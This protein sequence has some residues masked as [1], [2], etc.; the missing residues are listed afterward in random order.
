MT[1]LAW[2]QHRVTFAAVLGLFVAVATLLFVSGQSMHRTYDELG[3]SNCLPPAH[4][5]CPTLALGLP[6]SF[7]NVSTWL[8]PFLL[9]PGL[10]G[11]FW[12]GPLVAREL[13]HGTHRLVWTQSISRHRWLLVKVAVMALATIAGL[14]ALTVLLAWWSAPAASAYGNSR[15]DPL[16]FDLLGIAPVAYG[17]AALALG[18]SAGT[19]S[20]KVVPAIALT[21]LALAVV[22]VGVEVGLRP[23]FMAPE[24]T[25]TSPFIGQPDDVGGWVL[26]QRIVAADGRTLDATFRPTEAGCGGTTAMRF[27]ARMAEACAPGVKLETRHHPDD[28]YWRFQLTEAALYLMLAAAL[29]SLSAWWIRH[30]VA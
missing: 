1:W 18:I 4:S 3:F 17:L 30:R 15:L 26:D 19:L 8:L 5:S 23:H 16:R 22:R 14:T 29:V 20:R 27:D 9:V 7:R 11:A 25:V 24:T 13:E 21:L 12:G 10:I 6:D 28:R 2:R